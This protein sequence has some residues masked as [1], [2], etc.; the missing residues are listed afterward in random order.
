MNSKMTKT[1]KLSTIEPKRKAKQTT[2]TG[3]EP[4][5]WRSFGEGKGENEG[6]GAGI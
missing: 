4:K 5:I 1:P 6:K 3:T 2:R